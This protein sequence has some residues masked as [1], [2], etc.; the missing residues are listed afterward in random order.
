[1]HPMREMESVDLAHTIRRTIIVQSRRANVGHIGSALSIA[2]LV[3]ILFAECLRPEGGN[4][5][6]R[7]VLSKGHAALA[8]YA[9]LHAQGRLDAA[10]L[11]SFC[12]D[13]S[14][15]GVHPESIVAGIDFSTGSLGQGLSIAAGAALAARLQGS[16]RRVYALLS[17]AELNEGST[18]EALMFAGHHRL[19]NLVVIIDLN[20]QQ[21]F[22]FTADVI[23]LGDV[24]SKL[25]SFGWAADEVAGHDHDAL[26][27]AFALPGDGRPRA[28]VARTTFGHGVSFMESEIKWHYLPL[29]ELTYERAMREL[30]VSG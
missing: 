5:R 9:A 21:A 16:Q 18:W 10:T 12:G 25:R 4:D 26:R 8:L 1:M 17:D 23:D 2:D 20:G 27:M 22:D 6:D 28:I 3:A 29:D 15:L 24:A 19:E 13:G 14:Y 30:D 7:F 11:D